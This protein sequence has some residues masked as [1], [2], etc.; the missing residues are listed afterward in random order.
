VSAGLDT[1][2]QASRGLDTLQHRP[3]SPGSEAVCDECN[4]VYWLAGPHD[5]DTSVRNLN[6]TNRKARQ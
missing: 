1:L 4:L 2:P 5:C 6:S 3:P